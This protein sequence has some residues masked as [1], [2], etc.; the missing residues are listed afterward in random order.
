MTNVIE[1]CAGSNKNST[2]FSIVDRNA[3]EITTLPTGIQ[4]LNQVRP[5]MIVLDVRFSRSSNHMKSVSVSASGTR[6]VN[7]DAGDIYIQF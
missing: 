1:S 6:P 7:T 3:D 4:S 5:K 2:L